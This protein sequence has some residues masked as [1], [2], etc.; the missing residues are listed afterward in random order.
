[1]T[2]DCDPSTLRCAGRA[3]YSGAIHRSD[4]E[5]GNPYN[6]YRHPGLPLADRQSRFGCHPRRAGAGDTDALIS[7]CVRMARRASVF[8]QHGRHRLPSPCTAV[9]RKNSDGA[10]SMTRRKVETTLDPARKT[11][12]A[13]STKRRLVDYLASR[14]PSASLRPSGLSAR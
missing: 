3:R 11:A 1:M 14:Q 13:T 2:L 7:C 10:D 4:L 6:T 8:Q 12:C 5:S 9:P